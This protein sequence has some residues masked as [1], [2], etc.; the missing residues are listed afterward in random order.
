MMKESFT[1]YS[2]R[3]SM[4]YLHE[5]PKSERKNIGQFLTPVEVAKYMAS[6]LDAPS[7]EE[8]Y[9]LDPG[10]G[11]GILTAA[12]IDRL[13]TCPCVKRI[14]VTCY[15]T[16]EKILPL[17]ND[18][19]NYM[20]ANSNIQIDFEI[21]HANYITDQSD[22]FNGNPLH[23]IRAKKYDVIIC[24]PPYRKI[25]KD[26]PEAKCMKDICYGAPNLYFLFM[27]MGLF[28]L[29]EDGESVFIVPRS[30]TSG[31]YFQKFREYFLREGRIN[32]IHLFVSRD[33]VFSQD[34]ILQE[35]MIIKVVKT[36]IVDSVRIT[37]SNSNDDF[38]RVSCIDVPYDMVVSGEE[39]YVYLVTTQ[40]EL[41]ILSKLN[42]WQDS[43][44]SLGLKM[45]TGLT[46]D[47]RHEEYLKDEPEQDTVPL[48][49]SQH[50]KNGRVVFPGHRD[51]EYITT[52]KNGLI[53][54]NKNYLLV[55]R[56]TAKEE[57]RR[58]QCGIYLADDF[59]EYDYISTQNKVNFV[60]AVQS[61]MSTVTTYGLY[62]IFNSTVY[63][64]YYRILNGST[65]VNS[66]E[67]N[68]MP[69]PSL[70]EINRMGEQ[71]MELDDL[72]VHTCDL[73]MG[74]VMNEQG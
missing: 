45:K 32:H 64:R 42:R 52:Q 62:V 51:H 7:K 26:A 30:W 25:A 59:P 33:K 48:F 5:M 65:Q 67:I 22:F 56:F 50:I 13:L 10:S 14:S 11:S 8:V 20:K 72:S 66:T 41:S 19:L 12:V 16:C 23:N 74:G 39:K 38:D 28:N 44:P 21:V 35:T 53:Q 29:D 24:N 34:S 46:V 3:K 18:N 57:K 58:L 61:E 15:E 2:Y 9:I 31:A 47:F 54:K 55:K 36:S 71:L 60:E 40:E 70:E 17:L 68:S 37:S 4:A 69:I 1:D 27:A 63:D 49:Y 43:L 6:L 73:I